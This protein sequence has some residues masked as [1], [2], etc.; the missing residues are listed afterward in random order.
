MG[1]HDEIS[2]FAGL[3]EDFY[4]QSRSLDMDTDFTEDGQAGRLSV[5]AGEVWGNHAQYINDYRFDIANQNLQHER[6][7]ELNAR[8]IELQ[9]GRPVELLP[10]RCLALLYAVISQA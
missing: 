9:V 4:Y 8:F 10:V 3:L 7:R 2:R 1:S 6:D 5:V